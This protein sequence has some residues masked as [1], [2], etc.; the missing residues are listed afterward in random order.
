MYC[1]MNTALLFV[2][3]DEPSIK[4]AQKL[5][6][7]FNIHQNLLEFFNRR[8]TVPPAHASQ[9]YD[10]YFSWESPSL[11]P[12]SCR[13]SIVDEAGTRATIEL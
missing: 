12:A 8:T 9:S 4:P 6:T 3:I 7:L 2:L 11:P 5:L 10:L 1:T 13:K